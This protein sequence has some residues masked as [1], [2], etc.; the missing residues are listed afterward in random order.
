M[1]KDVLLGYLKVQRTS[2]VT[3]SRSQRNTLWRRVLTSENRSI[4]SSRADGNG[5]GREGCSWEDPR[6]ENGVWTRAF[7]CEG[8]PGRMLAERETKVTGM[9]G[10]EADRAPEIWRVRRKEMPVKQEN[11]NILQ[12]E[13]QKKNLWREKYQNIVLICLNGLTSGLPSGAE[14]LSACWHHS[15]PCWERKY[16]QRPASQ[17]R[18]SINMGRGSAASQIWLGALCMQCFLL[19]FTRTQCSQYDYP[20]LQT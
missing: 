4:C 8:N 2:K 19:K 12:T 18:R 3:Q 5:P 10:E 6:P 16:W 20:V 15:A 1:S 9:A 14:V 13:S 7:S 11:K 17:E